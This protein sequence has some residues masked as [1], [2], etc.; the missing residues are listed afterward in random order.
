MCH[1]CHKVGHLAR[2]CHSGLKNQPHQR[3][4]TGDICKRRTRNG[5][6]TM[7]SCNA[8][9]AK[10]LYV[11]VELCGKPVVMQLD[12]GSAKS[13]IPESLYQEHLV[14]RTV[15][16]SDVMLHTYNHEPIPHIGFVTLDVKYDDQTAQL[17]AFVV[18]GDKTPLLGRDW[19]KVLKLNWT[20]IFV[21]TRSEGNSVKAVLEKH[22]EVFQER[23]GTIQGYKAHID[24][25]EKAQLQ[26]HKARSVPYAMREKVEAE[27]I[28]LQ[29]ENTIRK[30]EHSDWSA[31]IVVVPKTNKTVR[32]C[33]DFKVTNNTTVELE[34]Y[35]LPNV[36]DLFASL[37]GVF[38]KQDLSHAYQQLELDA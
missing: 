25:K 1:K 13:L 19:L 8:G 15:N 16:K 33:G 31:P 22:K 10:P 9:G 32:I 28:S 17:S 34:H 4:Q 18:K 27:L 12:T 23:T 37:A 30:V 14:H 3:K 20:N 2:K 26:F 6:Y 21:V 24:M 7:Y 35:P 5:V 36:E 11:T 29:E 38:S